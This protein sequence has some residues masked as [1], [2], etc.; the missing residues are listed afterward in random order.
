MRLWR[1]GQL[2]MPRPRRGI[3]FVRTGSPHRASQVTCIQGTIQRRLAFIR[4]LFG[5][6]IGSLDLPGKRKIAVV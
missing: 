1:P 3:R 2:S 4:S 6:R 5:I